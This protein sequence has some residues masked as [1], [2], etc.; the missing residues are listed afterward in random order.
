[1]DS[2]EVVSHA[3]SD[4][5]EKICGA[6]SRMARVG[7][8]PISVSTLLK[9]EAVHGATVLR[10]KVAWVVPFIEP[11]LDPGAARPP[12]KK[13]D[14]PTQDDLSQVRREDG[15]GNALTLHGSPPEV[16]GATSERYF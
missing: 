11:P 6:L 10:K 3:F 12:K 5:L 8:R 13:G 9:R 15:R 1:M 4:E 2:S 16:F 7:K 14:T